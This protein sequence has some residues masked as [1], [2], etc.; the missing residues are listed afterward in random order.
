MQLSSKMEENNTSSDSDTG[1]TTGDIIYM[2]LIVPLVLVI[3]IGNLVCLLVLRLAEGLSPATKTFMVSLAVSDLCF[4]LRA[5]SSQ[6]LFVAHKFNWTL[7]NSSVFCYLNAFPGLYCTS[8]GSV[9]VLLLNF[10]AFVAIVKPLRYHVI[11]TSRRAALIT[12]FAWVFLLVW[13]LF[14]FLNILEPSVEYLP[15][16]RMCF[17]LIENILFLLK[18]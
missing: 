16:Y 1:F 5:L 12:I 13:S 7:A 2:F 4:G 9:S 11:L 10:D 15:K 14:L 6:F 18:Y 17:L 8:T 3:I